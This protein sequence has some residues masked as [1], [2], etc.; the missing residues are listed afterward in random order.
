[1]GQ[2]L[3]VARCLV[4]DGRCCTAAGAVT[5]TRFAAGYDACDNAGSDA[6]EDAGAIGAAG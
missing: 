1:M 4:C 2:E 5:A 6:C 3:A